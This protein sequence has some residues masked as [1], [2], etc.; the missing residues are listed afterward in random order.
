MA[1][2]ISSTPAPITGG[3]GKSGESGKLFE[4]KRLQALTALQPMSEALED[5]ERELGEAY[6]YLAKQVYSGAPRRIVNPKTKE[7]L[8][9]N[10]PTASGA[11]I[12][13]ISKIQ[14]HG[15][16]ISLAKSGVSVKRELLVKYIDALQV[17][18]NPLLRTFVET[19]LV[20]VLP[21]LPDDVIE[22][23]KKLSQIFLDVQIGRSMVEKAQ[24]TQAMQQIGQ[25]PQQGGPSLP[26]ET[27]AEGGGI[28]PEGAQIPPGGAVPVDVNNVNQLK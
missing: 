9:L 19:Q 4:E 17:I 15:I 10:V 28:S 16:I 20:E 6:F 26:G 14:R 13:D 23:G 25:F 8:L 21:N 27:P 5:F 12:N 7:I 18:Q 24:L 1:D 22:Q 11:I 2:L 3:T